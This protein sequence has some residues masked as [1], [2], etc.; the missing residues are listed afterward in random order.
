MSEEEKN[1]DEGS[2]EESSVKEEHDYPNQENGGIEDKE[3]Q[4]IP[5]SLL[6]VDLYQL[7]LEDGEVLSAGEVPRE[8]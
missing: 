5:P 6:K 3:L 2:A 1:K 7:G 4:R 8:C